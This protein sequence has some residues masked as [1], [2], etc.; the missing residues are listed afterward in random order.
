MIRKA[1]PSEIHRLIEIT[2]ACARKMIEEGI[3]Q[4]NESYPHPEAFLTDIE[5]EELFVLISGEEVAGCIVI[6]TLKDEVYEPVSW[7]SE[8]GNNYYVHRLAIHPDY[9]HQGMAKTLMDFAESFA[10]KHNG[11]SIRLDTFSKNKRN[12]RFYEARGYT[13]LEE[14]Y[15]PKQSEFPFY[16]FELLLK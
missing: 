8:D 2:R 9:Q 16:C 13:K 1:K 14:I 10:R 3:C 7:L 6:S 4:W 15:F 12:Q 5:R 11:D